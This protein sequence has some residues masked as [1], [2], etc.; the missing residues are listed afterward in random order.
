MRRS[1]TLQVES[2]VEELCFVAG[3]PKREFRLAEETTVHSVSYQMSD[4]RD[5]KFGPERFQA[6]EVLF[7][8]HLLGTS[9]SHGLPQEVSNRILTWQFFFAPKTTDMS[10]QVFDC[11][12]GIENIETRRQLWSHIVITGKGS[13]LPG[14]ITRFEKEL[15]MLYKKNI[16]DHAPVGSN[17]KQVKTLRF[18]FI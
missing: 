4:G 6:C 14:F 2:I 10:M 17:Q 12:E 9:G 1:C 15:K 16:V 11:I 3:D 5:I 8:P 18:V 7:Q 13:A